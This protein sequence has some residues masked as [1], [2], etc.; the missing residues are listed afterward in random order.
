[1]VGCV[2]VKAG[3]VVGRGIPPARRR[4]ARRGRRA[5][6]GPG[7]RRAR[8]HAY[9]NLE[10]CSH[11][12]AHAALRARSW[13]RRASAAWWRPCATPTRACDGRGLALLRRAGRAG[14]AWASSS[15]RGARAQRALRRGRARERRPFVLLKAALTL[16]GRIATASGESKWITSAARSAAAARRLRRLHDGVAGG[17]RHRARRRS[18]AAAAARACAAPSTGSCFDSRLRLPLGSRLV[19]SARRAPGLG[20]C[21]RAAPQARRARGSRRAASTSSS[22]RSRRGRVACGCG[23]PRAARGAACGSLMVEGGSELLGAFLAARPVRPG[24]AVPRA[25]APGRPRRAARLRRARPAR[26]AGARRAPPSRPGAARAGRRRRL[27]RALVP[28]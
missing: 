18:A 28:C 12:G 23:A 3:R 5:A 4:A 8:R 24:G 20:R 13:P 11:Q 16:D 22:V 26:L 9:V 10:P 14:D 7:A 17:H 27:V 6:R 21:A 2:V 19:R 1:M 25:A 15:A